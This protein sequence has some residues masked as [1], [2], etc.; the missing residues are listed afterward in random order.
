MRLCHRDFLMNLVR[1]VEEF[2]CVE[3][4]NSERTIAEDR[5]EFLFR[6][7]ISFHAFRLR[8]LSA[9]GIHFSVDRKSFSPRRNHSTNESTN[10]PTNQSTNQPA[11]RRL[12][13][14]ICHQ[15]I[16]PPM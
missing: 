7:V 10:Q 16:E 2:S 4:V 11:Q 13:L 12:L 14:S 8:Q 9:F 3:P 6:A 1:P 15:N 5:S